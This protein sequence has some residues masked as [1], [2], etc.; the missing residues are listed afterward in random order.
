MCTYINFED[1]YFEGGSA[2]KRLGDPE[3][4]PALTNSMDVCVPGS[5]WFNSSAM[6]VHSQLVCRLPVGVRNLLSL[7]L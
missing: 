5:P 6:L 2:A 7:V 4:S 1:L 3:L